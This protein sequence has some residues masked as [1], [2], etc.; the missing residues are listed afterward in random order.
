M[1][2][3]FIT[4]CLTAL[5]FLAFMYTENN[6][7][8]KGFNEANEIFHKAREIFDCK[9][10]EA[11]NL[12]NAANRLTDKQAALLQTKDDHIEILQNHIYQLEKEFENK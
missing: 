1:L 5:A 9:I 7:W 8:Y 10:K 3:I 6:G 4:C 11:E 12:V 2:E